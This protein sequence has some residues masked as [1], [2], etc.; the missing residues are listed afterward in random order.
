MDEIVYWIVTVVTIA[1]CLA[2]VALLVKL[3]VLL[4]SGGC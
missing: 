3:A 1:L 4:A 2:L